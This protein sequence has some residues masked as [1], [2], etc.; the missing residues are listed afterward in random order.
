[1]SE[2]LRERNAFV[3]YST[4]LAHVLESLRL[5]PLLYPRLTFHNLPS[6]LRYGYQCDPPMDPRS[7]LIFG[8][9]C[10][11]TSTLFVYNSPPSAGTGIH[12]IGHIFMLLHRKEDYYEGISQTQLSLIAYVSKNPE[13]IKYYYSRLN[14]RD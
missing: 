8:N 1:M 13:S 14:S 7:A 11:C 9:G 2:L 12:T 3:E 4:L 5:I 6:E 10:F